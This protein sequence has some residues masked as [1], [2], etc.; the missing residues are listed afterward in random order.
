VDEVDEDGA[1]VEPDC[2][3]GGLLPFDCCG[4]GM[5]LDMAITISEWFAE[6]FGMRL[7]M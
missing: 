2:G 1:D 6:L 5:F 3:I 4:G 7:M